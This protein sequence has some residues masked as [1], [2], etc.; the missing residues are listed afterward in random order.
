MEAEGELIMFDIDKVQF[1]EFLST[2]RKK[3]GFTQK[4]LAARL[5][6]SDKAVSKWE[7]GA[8][9]PDISLLIPLADILGV[10]V[11]ELLEGREIEKDLIEADHVENLVK[12][13][14]VLSEES[15][16]KSR[17]KL[18]RQ[19]LIFGVSLLVLALEGVIF[20]ALGYSMDELLNNNILLII[21]LS[22][23]FGAY[24]RFGVK[25]RL[26]TYYDEN[27]ISAYNDGVFRM[28][29]PGI[30]FNNSNWPYIVGAGRIW[31]VL[32]V[33]ILPMLYLAI[34]WL[35]S[36][37]WNLTGRYIIFILFLGGLFLPIYIVG[38]KYE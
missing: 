10:T 30:H 22:L 33:T 26:P 36:D 31:S 2:Q 11:T 14:L 13:A 3:K 34:N 21:L 20:F 1:G 19:G 18:I 28:N 24:F 17:E 16:V 12:K 6:I 5:F 4:E 38:K 9:M 23:I 8:S 15:P 29:I 7:R 37:A 27:K 35:D 32:S 25:D